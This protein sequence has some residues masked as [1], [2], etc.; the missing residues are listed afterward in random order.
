[1]D[2]LEE[3]SK[4]I[5]RLKGVDKLWKE[6]KKAGIDVTKAQVKDFVEGIG[7][8]QVLAQ[9]QPSLGKSA[10]TSIAKEGSR[11]QVDL[12]QFRFSQQ[13]EDTDDEEDEETKRYALIIIN[14]FDRKAHAVTL[15]DKSAETVLAGFRKILHKLGPDMKGGVLSSDM[16][17]EFFNDDF[18]RLLKT[19]DIAWKSKGNGEPN[20][21]AVLDRCIGTIRKD[22]SARMMEEPGKTWS[23]VLSASLVAYNRSIHGTMRDA[24]NDVGK[25]PVLQYLQISDNAKKYAHNDALAKRRVARVR[26]LGAFRRPKKAKAFKRGF[27]ATF[28]DK[29]VLEEVT[30]GTLLKARGDERK[31]DVKSALPVAATTDTAAERIARPGAMDR[32]RKSKTEDIIS[33]LNNYLDVGETRALTSIGRWLRAQMEDGLYDKTLKSVNRNLAGVLELWPRKFELIERGRNY[34]VKRLR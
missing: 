26:E 20:A 32:R 34:F 16:G 1:M 2:A 9:S 7:Q 14:V 21:I 31:I 6:A 22:V 5:G 18:Q 23:Q 27:E 15:A 17:R 12:I 29:E 10:T 28:G 11:F 13:E 30:D 24:P 4:R 25:E 3:L 19:S 33:F 8:K